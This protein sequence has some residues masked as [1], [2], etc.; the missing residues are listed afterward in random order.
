M[1]LQTQEVS[2]TILKLRVQ[3]LLEA[4]VLVNLVC[5]YI[6]LASMPK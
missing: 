3:S 1:R 2:T 6:F 5:P 4:T